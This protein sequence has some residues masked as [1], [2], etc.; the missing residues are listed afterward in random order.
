MDSTVSEY[1]RRRAERLAV[2][3]LGSGIEGI[4]PKVSPNWEL[5]LEVTS[6]Q[7][8]RT[9]RLKKRG[10]ESQRDQIDP[11]R[12]DEP[13][14]DSDNNNQGGGDSGGGH[15]NTRLPFGLCKRF[16]IEIGAD[17]GPRDAWDALAGRGITPDGAYAR[18][19]EGKDP[20]T[21]DGTAEEVKP[22]E[23]RKSASVSIGEDRFKITGGENYPGEVY[24]GKPWVL[25]GVKEGEEGYGEDFV[26][27]FATK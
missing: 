11:F 24:T 15:G 10:I 14:D 13:D 18:L 6:Y 19:K 2:R 3:G 12:F 4:R 16:G 7:K 23:P 1:K 5:P 9:E 27:D 25:K 8:R 17:W 26:K 20:G 22:E 21:P